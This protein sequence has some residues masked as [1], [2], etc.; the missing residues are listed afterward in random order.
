MGGELTYWIAKGHLFADD[1]C[2]QNLQITP[3]TPLIKEL[4]T[5]IGEEDLQ[6]EHVLNLGT[7]NHTKY[8]KHLLCMNLAILDERDWENPLQLYCKKCDETYEITQEQYEKEKRK[9]KHI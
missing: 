7:R 8:S 4:S 5:I 3:G 1:P 2:R 6:S 9:L